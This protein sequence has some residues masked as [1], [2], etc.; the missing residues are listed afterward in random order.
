VTIQSNTAFGKGTKRLKVDQLLVGI[1]DPAR[2]D[3]DSRRTFLAIQECL[4]RL[5]GYLQEQYGD[6]NRKLQLLGEAMQKPIRF[7]LNAG[8]GITIEEKTDGEEWTISA[9]NRDSQQPLPESGEGI[10]RLV[11]LDDVAILSMGN[12]S[13]L[14]YNSATEEWEAFTVEHPFK[15]TPTGA[16]TGTI[17]A[18]SLY[19]GG[20]DFTPNLTVP[21]PS[22]VTIDE[23]APCY[24]I[25]VVRDAQG[26]FTSCTWA[27]AAAI[28]VSSTTNIIFP[29][30]T[31]DMAGTPGSQYISGWTQHRQSDI[32]M[33]G[34]AIRYNNNIAGGGL[35]RLE[36]S[37]NAGVNWILM[38][39]GDAVA[40]ST[41]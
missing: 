1:P 21:V 38:T 34:L 36:I 7:R 40:H 33:W 2:A 30:L 25:E 23:A 20:E 29:I 3:P 10:T 9:R 13:T 35:H 24:Y 5:N 27:S 39:G 19:I 4:K 11:D 37:L 14:I 17:T 12:G 26:V 6:T 18:G 28:P 16:K 41:L 32:F 31:M 8:D 22:S 15:F